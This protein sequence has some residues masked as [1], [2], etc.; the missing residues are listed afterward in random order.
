MSFV[1]ST[2]EFIKNC[3]GFRGY[4]FYYVDRENGICGIWHFQK[5]IHCSISGIL[6]SESLP[7]HY[8]RSLFSLAMNLDYIFS[9][10]KSIAEMVLE[11][12]LWNFHG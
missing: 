12:I 6:F 5:K 3:L 4:N 1:V 11:M 8:Q 7:Y 9:H 2:V 10:Q